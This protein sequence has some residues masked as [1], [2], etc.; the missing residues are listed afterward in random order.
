MCFNIGVY[1][2]RKMLENLTRSLVDS[3]LRGI[4]A[5]A[6]VQRTHKDVE[7][8]PFVAGNL[9]EA[10]LNGHFHYNHLPE[11]VGRHGI[12]GPEKHVRFV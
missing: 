6:N 10:S 11:P 4:D 3:G 7:R 1:A 8:E 2:T 5:A 9:R 12:P